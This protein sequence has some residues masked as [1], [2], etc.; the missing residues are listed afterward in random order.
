MLFGQRDEDPGVR[1][2]GLIDSTVMAPRNAYSDTLAEI[3]AAYAFGIAKNHGYQ[4]GNKRTAAIALVMFLEMNG[5]Q[6]PIC[7]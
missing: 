4:N 5:V 3:A 2:A 7:A 6:F 1:D